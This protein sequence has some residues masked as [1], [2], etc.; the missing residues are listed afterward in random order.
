VSVFV[1]W[2]LC[3]SVCRIFVSG[4]CIQVLMILRLCRGV[5]GLRLK[6]EVRQ[7][8][9]SRRR[10]ILKIQSRR[11]CYDLLHLLPAKQLNRFCHLTS[12]F[13]FFC[14]SSTFT[15]RLDSLSAAD[16]VK[17]SNRWEA[18]KLQFVTLFTVLFTENCQRTS[19][20]V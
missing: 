7:R 13:H 17:L 8:Q 3:L 4:S 20:V 15:G 12:K 19:I 11:V 6:R 2:F 1:G 16:V 14:F 5:E 10:L 18:A 9:T